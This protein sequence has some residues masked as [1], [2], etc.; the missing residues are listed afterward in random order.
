[1]FRHTGKSRT[2]LHNLKLAALLSLVAGIVNV[3]GIFAI[4]ELTT[5]VTG[6]FAFFAEE[7]GK[8]E[9]LNAIHYL[10]FILSFFAGAFISSLLVESISRINLRLTNII[11]ILLEASILITIPILGNHFVQFHAVLIACCLLFAMGMQN[12]LVTQISN[13]VVRTTHLTGLFTDLGIEL[14]QLFYFREPTQLSRLKSSIRL[15]F[16]IILFFF[17]GCVF[18][19]FLYTYIQLYTLLIAALFLIGGLT[20]DVAKFKFK[21]ML[22]KYKIRA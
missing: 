13:S 9:Y 8:K 11:P 4:R 5:N 3:S 16:M 12:A 21:I 14:A 20:Y 15:R 22:R 10:L 17:S 7:I 2:F 18:G 6:H 1:M 19:G